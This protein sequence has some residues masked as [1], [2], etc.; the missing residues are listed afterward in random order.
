MDNKYLL[1]ETLKTKR[2]IRKN[3]NKKNPK[4]V[5]LTNYHR[6]YP[7]STIYKEG[8]QGSEG[9]FNDVTTGDGNMDQSQLQLPL[10]VSI[11]PFS[12]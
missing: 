7:P 4:L 11:S 10:E 9:K 1:L 2:R 3:N 5:S 8:Y 6:S 12:K